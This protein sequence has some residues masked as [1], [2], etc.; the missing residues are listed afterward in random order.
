MLG[1]VGRNTYLFLFQ[2]VLPSL[3]YFCLG[4]F[5]I[6]WGWTQYK[7]PLCRPS[8]RSVLFAG[9]STFSGEEREKRRM[10]KRNL[11]S[12]GM[13]SFPVFPTKCLLL[14]QVCISEAPSACRQVLPSLGL[15]RELLEPALELLLLCWAQAVTQLT[16]PACCREEMEILGRQSGQQGVLQPSLQEKG[17]CPV[18][19]GIRLRGC[20]QLCLWKGV[21][22]G[23]SP[24]LISAACHPLSGCVA[25]VPVLFVSSY[26][27]NTG[28]TFF[29]EVPFRC[30][31][32]QSA[33]KD[34]FWSNHAVPPKQTPLSS[35]TPHDHF[36]FSHMASPG[37]VDSTAAG[38]N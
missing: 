2:R 9:I 27:A 14:E 19:K 33:E 7:S 36:I 5:L 28:R 26:Q 30:Q 12:I 38:V 1:A 23:L 34:F 13:K 6:S 8:W 32:W 16:V 24:A 22:Q 37:M 25:T 29:S 17:G 35:E 11:L 20:H 4:P 31:P 21:H 15:A 10:E 3:C 18:P